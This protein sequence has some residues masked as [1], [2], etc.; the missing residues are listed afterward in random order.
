LSVVTKLKSEAALRRR[1]SWIVTL[2]MSDSGK[3]ITEDR[4]V[5]IQERSCSFGGNAKLSGVKGKGT[6][7]YL[8]IPLRNPIRRSEILRDAG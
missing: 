3:G 8:R 4:M 6:R 5:C 7:K 2:T 1:N